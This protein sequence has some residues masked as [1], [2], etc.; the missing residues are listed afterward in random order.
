MIKLI[1]DSASDIDAA[2]AAQLGVVL[3]PMEIRIGDEEYLD[4]VNL[5][6]RQFFEK[7]IEADELPK[8]SQINPYRFTELYEKITADGSQ[9]IVITMSSKL[10][11]TCANAQAAAVPFA[12]K[13]FVVDSLNVCIGERILCQYALRLIADG[14][15]AEEIVARLDEQKHKI[16]LLALLDTLQYLKKGGRVSAITAFAGEMFAIKPVI[17]ITDGEVKVVGKAIGSKK[18][19][20]LLHTLVTRTGGI[21]FTMPYAT[22]Y[23]GLDD[24]VLKKYINDHRAYWA[25]QT[26]PVQS[27][28]R[29]N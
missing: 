12:G 13:V 8:T 19:N 26:D 3:L 1:I 10:S 15:S 22:A 25:E 14:L 28:W 27:Q 16:Q 21:D 4:G 17:S 5:S 29:S 20:N 2:E 23:S 24:T 9:A 11:G 18:G 7:L 6:H